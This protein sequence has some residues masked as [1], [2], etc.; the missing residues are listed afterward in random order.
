MLFYDQHRKG[1]DLFVYT[2]IVCD[3]LISV[4]KRRKGRYFSPA[5][6]NY[7]V[8]ENNNSKKEKKKI[9]FVMYVGSCE[10]LIIPK[11]RVWTEKQNLRENN[12]LST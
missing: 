12:N 3:Q 2:S 1:P 8:F 6:K 5:L 11:V 10:G 9:E 4:R 7:P